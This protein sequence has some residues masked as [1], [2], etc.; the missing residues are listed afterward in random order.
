MDRERCGGSRAISL[1]AVALIAFGWLVERP[2]AAAE[3]EQTAALEAMV[4]A[5]DFDAAEAAAR[6]LLR[7]GTLSRDSVARIYLQLGI[8]ASAKRDSA[9]AESAFRKALRLDRELRLS[10]SAGPHVAEAFQL[11]KTT[12]AEAAT[13]APKVVLTPASGGGA[14][15]VEAPARR[16]GDD[17]VRRVVVAIADVREDH[18]LGGAP[19]RFSIALPAS[20]AACATAT[21]SVLD[22]LGNELWPAVASVEVCRAAPLARTSTAT[23]AGGFERIEPPVPA[24]ALLSSTPSP[25]PPKRI[26]RA[27]W[28]AAATTGAAAIGT[29]VLGLVAL[30]RRDDYNNAFGGSA[31]ADQQ[32]QLRELA[33]TA[34]HRATA[35]ALVTTVLAAATVFLYLRG[36]F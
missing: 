21:A 22:E 27:T 20:V 34:E 1:V 35:G 33:L 11:A 7:S 10:A 4:R 30:E 13:D 24:T 18:D 15:S 12:P 32:R 31:T 6:A 9:G 23:P 25:P 5:A 16:P 3:V 36:R 19:L 28:V 2:V 26:S 29:A 17:L 14:L 8:V